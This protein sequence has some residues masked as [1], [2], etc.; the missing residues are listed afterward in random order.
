[1]MNVIHKIV[2]FGLS[3]LTWTFLFVVLAL[4][5][6]IR[7]RKRLALVFLSVALAWTYLWSMPAFG[8]LLGLPLERAYPPLTAD[9]TPSADLIV[10]LGGGMGAKPVVWDL[11]YPPDMNIG[12]DR[13]WHGANLFKAGKAPVVALTGGEVRSSTAPLLRDFGVPDSALMYFDEAQN[14]EDEA[15]HIRDFL[16]SAHAEGKVLLVTS[17]WHMRRAEWLF[18][19]AGIDV[20]PAATD[21]EAHA[22]FG[23]GWK[24]SDFVP[25]AEML[26]VNSR[27]FKEHFSYWCYRLLK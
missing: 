24:F 9:E 14:T 4:V 1:M 20:I 6:V 19:R 18:R 25:D 27:F 15:R 8:R 17:A 23:Q 11:S 7:N 3:P 10:I 21:Y 13:V 5:F 12:A 16:A 22:R 26:G 2:T